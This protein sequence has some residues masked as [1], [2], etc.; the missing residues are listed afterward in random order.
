MLMTHLA[1]FALLGTVALLAAVGCQ[2]EPAVDNP[3]FNAET[4]EVLT[5]FSLNVS[6]NTDTKQAAEIVQVPTG[7]ATYPAFRGID[8]AY[9]L[10]YVLPTDGSILTAD[11]TSAKFYDLSELLSSNSASTSEQRRVLE[12]SL[13]LSTNTLLFY[14]KAKQ[15][16][17][18]RAHV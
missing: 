1:K 17:I 8:H 12:M 16:E 15:G 11:A 13:P 7:S 14:G 4:Q 10:S 18:G 9:L 2:R 6:T 3:N 5:Q